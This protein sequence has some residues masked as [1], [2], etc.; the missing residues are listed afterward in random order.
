MNRRKF[1]LGASALFCAPAI[2]KADSLMRVVIPSTE[3]I[4]PHEPNTKIRESLEHGEYGRAFDFEVS[5]D[6]NVQRRI[7]AAAIRDAKE[8]LPLNTRFEIRKKLP[9]DYGRSSG[10]AWYCN[11]TNELFASTSKKPLFQRG[12]N[13]GFISRHDGCILLG[14]FDNDGVING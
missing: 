8:I 12:V 10:I 13:N 6:I 9:S 7:M 1:I 14:R 5:T 3:I 4:L 2:I 11:S